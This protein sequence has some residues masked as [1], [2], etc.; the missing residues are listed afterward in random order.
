MIRYRPEIDGLRALT[1][2][3]VVLFHARVRGFSGGFVGVDVFF[4]VSGY[5]ITALIISDLDQG[6]FSF[7]GFWERRARRILPALITVT[8]FAA[9]AG[10]FVL[11][12]ADYEGFLKS[13]GSLSLLS[14]NVYFW[15]ESSY[16]S[17]V[18]ESTPMIHTWPLA[19]EEQFYL[20]F[21]VFVVLTTE[22][23]FRFRA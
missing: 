17:A 21:P 2:I 9:A 1:V 4:V 5:L 15:R 7:W 13:V 22:L 6:R 23:S 20:L 14:S 16:F 11:L 18:G 10:W 8:L 12:P 19:V 3:G